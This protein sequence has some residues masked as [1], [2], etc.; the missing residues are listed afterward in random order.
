MG[1][2]SYKRFQVEVPVTVSGLDAA[3]NPF[4]QSATTVEIS[5]RG[6]RLRGLSCLSGRRGEP[7]Q[8]KYK[9]HS[10]IYCVSWIGDGT[11][12]GLVGLESAD[13]EE[14]IFNDRMPIDF[15]RLESDRFEVA[16]AEEQAVSDP[17]LEVSPEIA[18]R[19]KADRRHE[20]RRHHVRF[21]CTGVAC[22]WEQGQ[23]LAIKARL[24]EI[25]LGGCYIEIMSPLRT[26][27]Q[28]RL[29][30]AVRQRSICLDGVVRNS[31]PNFGMGIEF[32][33]IAPA[34]A[35]KLQRVVAELSGAAPPE[36]SA[37]PPS[38]VPETLERAVTQWFS[39]HHE[40]TRQQFQ[41]LKDKVTHAKKDLTHAG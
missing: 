3:G 36:I 25:S 41:E 6:L 20:E 40:L 38:P 18:A 22:L 8:V 34:E 31:Q 37:P 39:S 33:K 14:C 32:L 4:S 15:A 35:E 13:P 2:R 7:L 17:F 9:G 21:S 1:R 30:L 19:C 5:A 12:Q 29:E 16:S 10:A 11:S 27:T 28:V 26:G 24:N 23:E